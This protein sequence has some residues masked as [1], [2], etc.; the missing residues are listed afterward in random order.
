M[1]LSL[2]SSCGLQENAETHQPKRAPS[3]EVLLRMLPNF[4]A[5]IADICINHLGKKVDKID[6]LKG[7][8]M[9]ILRIQGFQI[10]PFWK[11]P[12]YDGSEEM[13]SSLTVLLPSDPLP[14]TNVKPATAP[15]LV[16]DPSTSITSSMPAASTLVSTS[17]FG[18]VLSASITSAK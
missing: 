16:L 14:M 7:M 13:A 4:L 2:L 8:D 12:P 18:S 9:K 10:Q 6:V 3:N 17:T 5:K 1:S 11:Y 15:S